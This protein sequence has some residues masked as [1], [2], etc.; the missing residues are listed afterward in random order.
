MQQVK[1]PAAAS[2]GCGVGFEIIG[3]TA[4]AEI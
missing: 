4:P 1:T 2:A 3:T